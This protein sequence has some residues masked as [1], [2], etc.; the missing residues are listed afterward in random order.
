[1]QKLQQ[2]HLNEQER[3]DLRQ[4]MQGQMS[5]QAQKLMAGWSNG[6]G[7]VYQVALQQPATTLLGG[8]ATGPQRVG[9]AGQPTRPIIK[10]GTIMFAV[11]DTGINSDE[12]S[13]ILATIVTGKLKGSKLIGDFSRVDMKVL[14]K[15]NLLNVPSFNHS[16]SINAM[17][18]DPDTAR[19][20]IAK[21]V[22]SHYLLRYG[23]L[24]AS[25]FLSGL[26]QGIINSGAT[27]NCFGP[28]CV[29][30]FKKLNTG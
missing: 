1:M 20:A 3:R 12:K 23:S 25:A 21:S 28:F 4:Q 30:T 16:F 22:N 18:I 13:L 5:L 11:L 10:A 6:S 2:E 26:S 24:F 14:L 15:F 27:Q 9:G 8:N 7:Q 19:T 29:T 17:A